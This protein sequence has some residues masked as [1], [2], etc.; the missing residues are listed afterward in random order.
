[1]VT[2]G[3]SQTDLLLLDKRLK[4]CFRHCAA[5]VLSDDRYDSQVI[6]LVDVS[7]IQITDPCMALLLMVGSQCSRANVDRF[8][9][10]AKSAEKRKLLSTFVNIRH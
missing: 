10:I 3:G 9:K 1:M 2:E 4:I 8:P 6:M 5:R 7:T